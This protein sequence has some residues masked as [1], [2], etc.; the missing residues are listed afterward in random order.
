MANTF[1][2]NQACDPQGC[3]TNFRQVW[4]VF[5]AGDGTGSSVASGLEFIYGGQAT[6]KS[7]TT[8]GNTLTINANVDGDFQV[9]SSTSGDDFYVNLWGR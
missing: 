2:I 6:Q 7:A 5:T 8:G 4:G 9:L 3:G 1:T